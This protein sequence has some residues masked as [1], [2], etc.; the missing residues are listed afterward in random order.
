MD[1]VN[2][3]CELL[4]IICY[5]IFL[6]IYDGHDLLQQCNVINCSTNSRGKEKGPAFKLPPKGNTKESWD[7]FCRS[8]MFS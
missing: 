8:R 7:W 1:P 3:C 6:L 2:Y 5:C 4:E